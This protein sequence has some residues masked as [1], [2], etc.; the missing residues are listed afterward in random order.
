[1]LMM[2]KVREFANKLKNIDTGIRSIQKALHLSDKGLF[3][4][5][6]KKVLHN[7]KNK[8]FPTKNLEPEV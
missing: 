7:F 3:F 2:S 1:M 6:R 8:P 5:T 4:T